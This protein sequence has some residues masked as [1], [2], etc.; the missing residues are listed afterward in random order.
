MVNQIFTAKIILFLESAIP[1]TLTACY[2]GYVFLGSKLGDSLLLQYTREVLQENGAQ[3]NQISN[4][5]QDV[6]MDEDDLYLYS[7][8]QTE[9]AKEV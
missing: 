2:P 8:K 3:R 6:Q 9:V 4:E 7:D 5:D 1:Y